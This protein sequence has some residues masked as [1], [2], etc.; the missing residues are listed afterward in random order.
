MTQDA[1]AQEP[2]RKKRAAGD[3]GAPYT[4]L[5]MDEVKR[6]RTGLD[7]SAERLAEEMAAM[8]VPWTRDVVVNLENGRRKTLAVHEVLTLACVLNVTSPLDLLAPEGGAGA[9]RIPVTPDALVS[10][11][12]VRDWI[13]GKI[14]PMRTWLEMQQKMFAVA[15]EVIRD[16][17]RKG[18]TN[19]EIARMMTGVLR[20]T[21]EGA[22]YTTRQ[23][24]PGDG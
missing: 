11:K 21:I 7:W 15:D 12:Y 20:D 4:K 3:E 9:A 5:I 17:A 14:G 2:D 19:E 13:A 6:L 1:A 10:P 24:E 16:S 23:R 18:T 22:P 8:G